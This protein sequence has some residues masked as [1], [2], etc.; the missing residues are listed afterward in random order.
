[1]RERPGTVKAGLEAGGILENIV[2]DNGR[3]SINT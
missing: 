2:R 3:T 1:M